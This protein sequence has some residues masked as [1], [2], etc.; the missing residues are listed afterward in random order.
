VSAAPTSLPTRLKE[1]GSPSHVALLRVVLGLHLLRVLLSPSLDLLMAIGPELHPQAHVLGGAA[2]YG[3]LDGD[4]VAIA[5]T[6]GVAAAGCVIAG[7][8]GRLGVLALLG[9]FLVT[10]F[11]WFGA[12]LFH[13]DWIFFVFPLL[14]LLTLTAPTAYSIDGWLLRRRVSLDTQSAEARLV[15]EAW[16][17]WI[18]F[19]YAAAGIAK[20]FPLVKGIEWLTGRGPQL[21]AV[22]FV[23]QSPAVALFGEPLFPY[24]QQW[25][26]ALGAVATVVLELGAAGLWFTRRLY[27]PLALGIFGMHL[28]FLLVGIP[29][30][31]GMFAVLAAALLPARGFAR[32][33]ARHARSLQAR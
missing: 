18:G 4:A 11:Y 3:S 17:F 26:F 30:F 16:V 22:E 7:L 9:S 24:D 33:D 27:L 25:I 20:L 32:A 5:R 13:D 21:F 14:S 10:Q 23:R 12:T 29:G 31:V 28:G 1:P 2:L 15:V 6:V 8:G 19:V